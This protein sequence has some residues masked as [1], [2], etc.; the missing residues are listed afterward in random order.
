MDSSVSSV[1]A[2]ELRD[3]RIWNSFLQFSFLCV[4]LLVANTIRR[5]VPLLRK[6]LL[7]TAVIGGLLI[8]PMRSLGWLG[9]MDLKF[10]YVITYHTLAV[11]FIALALKTAYGQGEYRR[12]A[13]KDAFNSGLLIVGTYLLQGVIGFAITIFLGYTLMPGLFKAAGLLLP[14]GFGQGPGQ[15]NNW[16]II[17]ENWSTGGVAPF[18]GGQSFGLSVASI[19][20]IWACIPGVIW[21]TWLKRKGRFKTADGYRNASVSD[22]VGLEDEIPL[23]ESIDKFTLQVCF[24]M[25]TFL[26]SFGFMWAVDRFLIERGLLGNFG[27]KTLRPLI[28]GFNFLF[29]TLFGMLVKN[30]IR[31]V[32]KTGLMSRVYLSNFML[33]RIAGFAFDFM[34]LAS[35]CMIDIRVLASLWVPLLVITTVGGVVTF[36]YDR[37]A[38]KL[39]YPHYPLEG[40]LAMYGMLTGTASTGVALLREADPNFDT[41]AS[42]NLVAGSTTAIAFGFPMLLLLGVA[43][44]QPL[45]TLG[46]FT[47]FFLGINLL[48]FRERI[49]GNKKKG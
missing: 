24:V 9:F 43:P 26:I 41:P 38:C 39:I 4:V 18:I 36:I 23:A 20:F 49:F 16:G 5:K 30:V 28:W 1:F 21:M 32:K 12:Q 34:I 14:L 29:G 33:N 46:L 11:G 15:A 42:T 8:L 19:G 35:I 45:L 37:F 6:S 25:L 7:P 40:F 44:N 47:A 48:L 22:E 31:M 27:I 13:G 17:Y 10:L 2:M 3:P